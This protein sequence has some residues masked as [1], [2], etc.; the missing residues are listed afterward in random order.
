MKWC[1]SPD[2]TRRRASIDASR[3]RP[4]IATASPSYHFADQP[5]RYGYR[6]VC[7]RGDLPPALANRAVFQVAQDLGAD[8][9]SA[10]HQQERHHLPALHGGHRRAADVLSLIHISEPTRQAEISYAVFCLKK[11]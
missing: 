10:E 9:S 2:A 5:V 4:A 6:R 3:S 8:G 11:K 7:H 1:N